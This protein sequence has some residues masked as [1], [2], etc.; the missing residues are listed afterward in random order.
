MGCIESKS[1]KEHKIAPIIEGKFMIDRLCPKLK[2]IIK[3]HIGT[4]EFH[5][6]S[7]GYKCGHRYY[8]I[9][10]KPP[11]IIYHENGSILA[12]LKRNLL[13]ENANKLAFTGITNDGKG[14]ITLYIYINKF[15]ACM[16]EIYVG[17]PVYD[18]IY[19]LIDMIAL[20]N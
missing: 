18:T 13:E 9:S 19:K 7:D 17:D 10:L 6:A 5:S 1:T 11:Y 8:K 20:E 15:G 16:G 12:L 2:N 4:L 3:S 14:M